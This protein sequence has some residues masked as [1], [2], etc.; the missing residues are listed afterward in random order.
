MS[1]KPISSASRELLAC[2]GP[3]N[4]T[5]AGERHCPAVEKETKTVE[6]VPEIDLEL[7]FECSGLKGS[8]NTQ[9]V[10]STVTKMPANRQGKR[11]MSL[12]TVGKTEIVRW[13][14]CPS[15]VEFIDVS[16]RK[17]DNTLTQQMMA[18]SIIH[19]NA[20]GHLIRELGSA[21]FGLHELYHARWRRMTF[22]CAIKKKAGQDAEVDA[23]G[24]TIT[25]TAVPKAQLP[26]GDKDA[27]GLW[28]R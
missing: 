1:R 8:L 22:Q 10:L 3:K 6:S 16:M 15:W 14:S 7:V 25:V 21:V 11:D 13:C 17:G 2:F 4:A 27:D 20:K 26:P 12:E 9:A 24:P 23:S 19:V 18:V 28:I 5:A